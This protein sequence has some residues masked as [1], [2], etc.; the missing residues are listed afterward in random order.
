MADLKL[1]RLPDRTPVKLTI[2]LTPDLHRLL[3]EYW[4]A[5]RAAYGDDRSNMTDLIPHIILGYIEGD[6]DFIRIRKSKSASM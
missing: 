6:R 1:G 4:A 3:E 5:Y 2:S